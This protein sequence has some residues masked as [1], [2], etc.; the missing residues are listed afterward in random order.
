MNKNNFLE[1]LKID[2]GGF[3]I[4]PISFVAIFLIIFIGFFVANFF[5]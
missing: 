2:K 3:I 4:I 1:N 5:E